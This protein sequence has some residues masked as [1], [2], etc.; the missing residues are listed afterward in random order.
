MSS[1]PA[2]GGG[3]SPM[4][5]QIP[6]RTKYSYPGGDAGS[7]TP[8]RRPASPSPRVPDEYRVTHAALRLN[9]DQVAAPAQRPAIHIAAVP[10]PAAQLLSHAARTVF[11][12]HAALQIENADGLQMRRMLPIQE[13]ESAADGEIE[14]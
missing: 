9:A 6:T 11:E 10:G 1:W 7:V 3:Q 5:R 2:L 4:R 14:A 12:D 13:Q 8:W